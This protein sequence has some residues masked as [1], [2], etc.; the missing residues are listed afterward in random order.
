[1]NSLAVIMITLNEEYHIGKAIENIKAIADE[2][3]VLDS[4][5]TDRT[6]DI[7][8][9]KGAIVVQRVFTNFGDQW[10]YALQCFDIKSQWT[11]KLDPDE[12]LSEKLKK[13]I[14]HALQM[15]IADA[16]SFDRRLW[17]MGKPLHAKDVVL[18]IWKTGTCVFSEAIVNEHPLVSGS[19]NNLDGFLEHLDSKDLHQW[20]I[21]QNKYSTMEAL[22]LF[23]GKYDKEMNGN[24]MKR[25]KMFIKYR[26]LYKIPLCFTLIYLYHL[27]VKG[28]WRDG[29][30]GFAWARL[31][32]EVFR[33]IY[34]KY[35]E[36]R[37]TNVI[38]N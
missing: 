15:P 24:K 11:M 26:V 22:A 2:I 20:N 34:Y 32:T 12:R 36:M 37:K 30:I 27:I 7:A 6:V 3:F 16:Y 8:R 10:N 9:E 33:L 14:L 25:L 21:K 28:S 13:S 35:L 23:T 5:S 1:M 19:V 4:F 31:R 29:K 18:R 38:K 17:F